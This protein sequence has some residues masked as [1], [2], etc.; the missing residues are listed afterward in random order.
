MIEVQLIAP[1]LLDRRV[2]IEN[3]LLGR[4]PGLS[5]TARDRFADEVVIREHRSNGAVRIETAHL[6]VELADVLPDCCH[7]VA[8]VSLDARSVG[9]VSVLCRPESLRALAELEET[10][11]RVLNERIPQWAA[12]LTAT[13]AAG[14]FEPAPEDALPPLR[15]L[16]WHRI[17]RGL[18]LDEGPE[19]ALVYGARA[20]LSG[21]SYALVGNGYTIV[22]G[23][24]GADEVGEGIIAAQVDWIVLDELNRELSAA[25]IELSAPGGTGGRKAGDGRSGAV[26][27]G[28]PGDD[29]EDRT[30]WLERKV[31]LLLLARD[32]GVRYLANGPACVREAAEQS[33]RTSRESEALARRAQAIRDLSQVWRARTTADRDERRN[34]IIWVLTIIV[35][36]QGV[37]AVYDFVTNN[38]NSIVSYL[39]LGVGGAFLAVALW[40]VLAASRA[41]LLARLR[42]R[43]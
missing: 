38:L 20:Q 41:Q 37:L 14:D 33:W 3:V 30:L 42:R 6:R 24:H 26:G 19:A 11:T 10:V 25:L 15:V 12:D 7:P 17:L 2:R 22:R 1:F 39:R 8:S 32:E 23:A 28:R 18:G 27:A 29:V 16:W 21:D 34:R 9:I 31:G 4:T 13:L 35:A 5:S 40:L 36:L 43:S